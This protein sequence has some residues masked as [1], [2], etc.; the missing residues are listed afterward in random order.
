[1]P[2]MGNQAQAVEC[3]ADIR[4]RRGRGSVFLVFDS[5]QRDTTT[6]HAAYDPLIAWDSDERD[7]KRVPALHSHKKLATERLVR[8]V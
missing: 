4:R 7:S 3:L 5:E 6:A 8:G 2:E 1:M